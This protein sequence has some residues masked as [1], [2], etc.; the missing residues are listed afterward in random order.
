M[1]FSE[2]LHKR[3]EPVQNVLKAFDEN[4]RPLAERVADRIGE[5][6]ITNDIQRGEKLPN[7]F[8]LAESLNVGRGPIR[9]AVKLLVSRNIL[10]IRRGKG[11]FVAQEPGVADDPYGLR[12]YEDKEKL[13]KDLIQIRFMLEPQIA[14]LAAQNASEENIKEMRRLNQEISELIRNGQRYIEKDIELHSCWAKSTQNEIIPHLLP[15]IH[16]A[17][18]MFFETTDKKEWM[19]STSAHEKIIT[20]IEHHDPNAARAAMIEHLSFTKEKLKTED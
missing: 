16:R 1:I 4:S 13:M 14:E 9:E 7:E 10:E 15:A 19:A 11:T 2:R 3:K 12:F 8:E 18:A 20:A 17:I 5:L 6:I